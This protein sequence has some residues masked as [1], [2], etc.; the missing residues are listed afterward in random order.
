M[1]SSWDNQ[2]ASLIQNMNTM[3]IA[4]RS[5]LEL[6][7]QMNMELDKIFGQP[8]TAQWDESEVA[9]SEEPSNLPGIDEIKLIET[10]DLRKKMDLEDLEEM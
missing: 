7:E 3:S 1:T 5:T 8:S 9:T 6:Q 10:M 4:N 2:M